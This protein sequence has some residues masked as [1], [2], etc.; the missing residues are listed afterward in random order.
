MTKIRAVTMVVALLLFGV[1]GRQQ[2]VQAQGTNWHCGFAYS[3][4]GYDQYDN[5]VGELQ[6]SSYH[7]GGAT[8]ANACEFYAV[9]WGGNWGDAACSA[10]GFT[11]IEYHSGSWYWMGGASGSLQ[12]GSR[13]C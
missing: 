13:P 12:S 10:H 7:L 5:L 11:R 1:P 3:I 4:N 2:T 6:N 8:S 9:I